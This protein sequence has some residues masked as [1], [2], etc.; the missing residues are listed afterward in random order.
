MRV[1]YSLSRGNAGT[2]DF[3]REESMI[4]PSKPVLRPTCH[5]DNSDDDVS[6]PGDQGMAGDVQRDMLARFDN[7]YLPGV[8]PVPPSGT[9]LREAIT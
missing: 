4:D 2:S 1:R 9:G 7:V 5:I 3:Q 6:L 8:D